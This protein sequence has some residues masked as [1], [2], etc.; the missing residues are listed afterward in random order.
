LCF[1]LFKYKWVLYECAV[2]HWFN[3][4]SKAPDEDM[5]MWIV[6]PSF[7]GRSPNIS[8]MH[9]NA[10]YHAAHLLPIYGTDYIPCNIN[11]YHSLDTFHAF[12]INKLADHHAF[13]IA[14]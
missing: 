14:F 4:I 13:E 7:D 6:Q 12:Y 2:V 11:F 1:F 8:V 3:V 9:I 10:I 5:G